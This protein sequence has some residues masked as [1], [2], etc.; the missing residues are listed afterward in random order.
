MD[1]DDDDNNDDVNSERFNNIQVFFCFPAPKL[2]SPV[3]S[4]DANETDEIAK[5]NCRERERKRDRVWLG[6]RPG[7]KT[8][9]AFKLSTDDR[10][11][12]N[13]VSLLDNG[14]SSRSSSNMSRN[15]GNIHTIHTAC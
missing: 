6:D 1:D 15:T 7:P 2:L 8:C 14:S 12:V 10:T 4:A 13:R 3:Q 11:D 5:V 9:R